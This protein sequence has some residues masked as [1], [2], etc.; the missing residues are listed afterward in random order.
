M[1]GWCVAPAI[2]PE[3]CSP[4]TTACIYYIL[5][6]SMEKRTKRLIDRLKE[7]G[8]NAVFHYVPLH[9]SPALVGGMGEGEWDD[10]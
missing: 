4:S 5:L 1:G 3:G 10:G 7:Q 8:V 2:I 9:S 6:E